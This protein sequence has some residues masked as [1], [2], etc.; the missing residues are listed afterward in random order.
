MREIAGHSGAVHAVAIHGDRIAS[1]SEDRSVR[2]A[3]PEDAEGRVLHEHED[4]ARAVAFSPDGERVASSGYDNS[5]RVTTA[6][7]TVVLAA[8]RNWVYRVHFLDR[9]RVLS[10]ARDRTLAL[11]DVAEQREVWRREGHKGG[12]TA[13]A[14]DPVRKRALSGG[15]DHLLVAWDMAKGDPLAG[16]GEGHKGGIL[17]LRRPRPGAPP[18]HGRRGQHGGRLAP[19]PRDLDRRQPRRRGVRGRRSHSLVG[20]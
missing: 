3:A 5:V 1:A 20:A 15:T 14:L 10:S 9:D 19:R 12:V 13:L 6:G 17:G 2:L 18:R 16:A 7:T 4:V 11:W 8:H